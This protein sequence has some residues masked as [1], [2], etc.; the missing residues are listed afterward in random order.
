MKTA[1]LMLT[2]LAALTGGAVAAADDHSDVL[3]RLGRAIQNDDDHRDR[4]HDRS[5]QEDYGSS[6]YDANRNSGYGRDADRDRDSSYDR[7]RQRDD[8]QRDSDRRRRDLDQ[9]H[10]DYSR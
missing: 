6:G 1:M 10:R 4:S 5:R 8:E 9:D 7:R 2:A 3:N